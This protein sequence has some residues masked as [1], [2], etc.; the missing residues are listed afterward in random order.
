[1]EF[2]KLP[3]IFLIII[4]PFLIFLSTIQFAGFNGSFY[5]REFLKYKVQESVPE[6]LELHQ[7]VMHFIKGKS[8]FLPDNFNDREKQHLYDVRRLVLLFRAILYVLIA[9]VGIF[10]I[11]SAK[12]IEKRSNLGQFIGKVLLFGGLTAITIAVLLFLMINFNFSSS[13]ESFHKIFFQP[14]TYAFDQDTEIIVNIYSEELFMDLG[15]RIA[16]FVAI[17]SFIFVIIGAFLLFRSK[18]IK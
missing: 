17:I 9:L 10:I 5:K 1:M 3:K 12:K 7:N 18:K 8:D 13:F 4:I 2:N 6:A 11:L 15:L 14:G 16:K